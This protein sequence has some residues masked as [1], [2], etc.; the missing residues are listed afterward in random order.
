VEGRRG[1][2]APLPSPRRVPAVDSRCCVITIASDGATTEEDAVRGL[3]RGSD[4]GSDGS[5]ASASAACAAVAAAVGTN[6][7]AE[8]RSRDSAAFVRDVLRRGVAGTGDVERGGSSLTSGCG[9]AGRACGVRGGSSAP[10]CAT[11]SGGGSAARDGGG[12]AGRTTGPCSCAPRITPVGVG[13]LART[14]SGACPRSSAVR[15]RAW[16]RVHDGH[17]PA[18]E[19]GAAPPCCVVVTPR[20]PKRHPAGL[21]S[22]CV[23]SVR[24]CGR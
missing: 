17:A 23:T 1:R 6:E 20:A 15:L 2:S 16:P 11:N 5:G 3:G 4:G 10:P 14:D 21:A 8:R 13:I 18:G 7:G 22:E 24:G 12:P 19:S 9:G